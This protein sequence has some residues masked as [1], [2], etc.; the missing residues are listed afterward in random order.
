M[1]Y[2]I[3]RQLSEYGPYTW[4]LRADDAGFSAATEANSSVTV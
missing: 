1:N 4:R 3:Q 2:Y